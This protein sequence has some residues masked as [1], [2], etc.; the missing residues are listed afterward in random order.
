MIS[1]KGYGWYRGYRL[2]FWQVQAP[3]GGTGK[4][5]EGYR[6]SRLA[7]LVIAGPSDAVPPEKAISFGKLVPLSTTSPSSGSSK[8]QAH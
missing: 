3:S 8:G 6:W 2:A 7:N 5:T 4:A 1:T